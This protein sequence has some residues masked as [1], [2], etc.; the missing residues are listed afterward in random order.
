MSNLV[1]IDP[2]GVRAAVEK[3]IAEGYRVVRVDAGT[4]GPKM[5]DWGKQLWAP[6]D[7]SPS[8]NVG[9]LLGPCAAGTLVNIDGDCLEAIAL[10][11]I[12]LPATGMI[13]G[14]P[15][16]GPAHYWYL[17]DEGAKYGKLSDVPAAPKLM[18]SK[19]GKAQTLIEYRCGTADKQLQTLVPPSVHPDSGEEYVWYSTNAPAL[20]SSALLLRA[21]RGIAAGALLVRHFPANGRHDLALALAGALLR[22]GWG[23]EQAEAFI[24][25]VYKIGGS[26]KPTERASVVRGTAAK[27]AADEP[28]TGIPSI[29][30][31]LGREVTDKLVNWL[32]LKRETA[33]THTMVGDVP[34]RPNSYL[35]AVTV[36]EKNI[37]DVLDGRALR[38]NDMT[39]AAELG[40]EPLTDVDVFRVRAEIE[41]R[42]EGGRDKRG[43]PVPMTLSL[44]DV[45]NAVVQA[46]SVSHYHPV[47]DYLRG[48]TWDGKT[49]F[50]LLCPIFG[51]ADTRLNRAIL[52][53]WLIGAAARPLDP[54]CKQDVMLV[55]VG[56]QGVRKSTAF[57]VLAGKWFCDSAIDVHSKDSFMTL[58]RAWILEWAELEAIARARDADAVKSFITSPID[59]Y[60]PAYG[61]LTEHVPRSSVCVGT[62]NNPEFLSDETGS[63]RFW[64]L[65][66]DFVDTDALEFARDQLW[67]E[68]VHYFEA[69]EQWWL[70][71]EEE[72]LIKPVH[73]A[74]AVH[75]A[76]EETVLEWAADP[77]AKAPLFAPAGHET[78]IP[79]VTTANILQHALG[80]DLK[81]W[82]R[83]DE[84]RVGKIMRKAGWSAQR[85]HG[86]A[87]V[88]F[89]SAPQK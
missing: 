58:R 23:E 55:L 15:G 56:A 65:A 60:R 16:R 11:P 35:T 77:R 86:G 22:S 45:Q 24:Y 87:R 52:S 82:N 12:F 38:Y 39:G 3:Y 32:D 72:A 66:V 26:D 36:V 1:S 51:A 13:S 74:H 41:R 76:W 25:A 71:A 50:H 34:L 33:V 69:G 89:P 81:S 70:T 29:H 40:G 78:G 57:K 88:W 21:T 59:T 27:L 68:A 47:Q 83:W 14:R 49:R 84:N 19:R 9:L 18:E 20:V 42:V 53:R 2:R 67:A 75:D 7:F 28:V 30:K 64:P 8:S 79:A 54:G 10:M 62:T 31:A 61:R 37:A 73:A 44:S 63:R 17:S 46:S 48:L 4:K 85:P 6:S 80:K 5:P 43:N